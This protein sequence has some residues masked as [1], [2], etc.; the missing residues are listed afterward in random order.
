MRT[1]TR[2]ARSKRFVSFLT[3]PQQRATSLSN[4]RGKKDHSIQIRRRSTSSRTLLVVYIQA[5]T[6]CFNVQNKT[7]KRSGVEENH[8][9]NSNRQNGTPFLFFGLVVCRTQ[10]TTKKKRI[11]A[12]GRLDEMTGHD[13]ESKDS[14]T[15]TPTVT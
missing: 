14:S 10:S 8:L 3:K 13:N 7:K 1:G 2:V 6:K 4:S 5:T 15:R 9:F 11:R 12:A